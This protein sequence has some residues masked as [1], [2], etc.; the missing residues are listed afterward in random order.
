MVRSARIRRPLLVL[1]L[2]AAATVLAGTGGAQA[3]MTTG[4]GMDD[5]IAFEPDRDLDGVTRAA[6]LTLAPATI[7]EAATDDDPPFL[8][9]MVPPTTA[10]D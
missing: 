7:V 8:C 5:V 10:D 2:V 6:Y 9:R 3:A 4:G 1:A